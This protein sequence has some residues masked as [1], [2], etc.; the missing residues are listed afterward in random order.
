MPSASVP[1]IA[2]YVL[3]YPY[4]IIGRA[5]VNWP[6]FGSL[7]Y[8]YSGT[9]AV[10]LSNPFTYSQ[11]IGSPTTIS[12]DTYTSG[13]ASTS[14]NQT[15][16]D[17][18][19]K[20]LTSYSQMANL[21]FGSIQNYSASGYTPANVGN[22]SNINISLI[23][24]PDLNFSG[25]S[26]LGTDT[27]FKY[28][29]SAGDII[30]NINGLGS[31]GLNNDVSFSDSSFGYHTLMHE[32][33][34][35]LGLTHPHLSSTSAGT[36]LTSYFNLTTSVGFNALGF[37]INSGADMNKDYFSIMSYDETL[38]PSNALIVAQSPMILDVIALQEL[39]G[40][41]TG[42]TGSGDDTVTPG[43]SGTVTQYR[44]Y[45]DTG[46]NNTINL[47]N[48]SSGAYIN[49]GVPIAGANH[50]VGV[51]MSKSDGDKLLSS[52][53]DPSSL[54]WYY[55]EFQNVTGSPANDLIYGNSLDNT[56]DGG[57]GND[58]IDGGAGNDTVVFNGNT[59]QYHL[60]LAADGKITISGNSINDT[61]SQIENIK[62][63][64]DL[65]LDTTSFT[66]TA[67]LAKD[68][69]VSI[70]ELYIASFNRAPDSLGLY[71]WGGRLS[72][73][74]SLQD[75]AK[76]F[77]VQKETIATYPTTMPTNDFVTLVYNNVLSRSPDK[78]GLDYWVSGLTNGSVSKDS[79]LLAIING[80]I[81]LTGS[82]TD[83]QTLSNKEA[84]GEHYAIYQGLN[85]S[86]DWAKNTMANV[87]DQTSTVYAANTKADNYASIA[88]ASAT[89]D[90]TVKLV[91]VAV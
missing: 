8:E 45:F 61:L 91:G 23:Y 79:F 47:I 1:Q 65:T 28:L 18:I 67:H 82:A 38:T 15:Q 77:F 16:L 30:I 26:A 59:S 33:G 7:N 76:S 84:V 89:S 44:T 32:I 27:N 36:V 5:L 75:I 43:A 72:D 25:E 55:G 88:L 39:Y 83:R 78:P 34:H 2:T 41:G 21:N 12:R 64:A 37:H 3:A 90:L 85:N 31:R 81:A 51:S 86:S 71:Y 40:A 69:L 58:V 6:A 62:L 87:T 10:S 60:A 57:G 70:V 9:I 49:M 17:N 19:T 80:A 24:R 46:G 50:L 73:G 68:A 66:K 13:N 20:I 52:G 22:L 29:G 74:M 4:T 56:I 53:T 14:W 42:S 48:Y 35:S 54:R 63:S 11:Y